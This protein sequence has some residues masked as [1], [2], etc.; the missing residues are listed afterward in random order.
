MLSLGNSE[1]SS[2]VTKGSVYPTV[3]A[4]VP[5]TVSESDG[6]NLG[7]VSPVFK[8]LSSFGSSIVGSVGFTEE[9]ASYSLDLPLPLEP[10]EPPEP[11]ELPPFPPP[12]PPPLLLLLFV[13]SLVLLLF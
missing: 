11:P 8:S 1:A 10:P 6:F 2:G 5:G 4:I 3:G 9:P 12:G 7:S 13:L